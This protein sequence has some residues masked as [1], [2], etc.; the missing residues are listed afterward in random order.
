MINIELAFQEEY[1]SLS[2]GWLEKCETISTRVKVCLTFVLWFLN[3]A[4]TI[5]CLIV[6]FVAC[7]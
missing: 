4:L 3:G 7:F 6:V 1:V 2:D 5:P